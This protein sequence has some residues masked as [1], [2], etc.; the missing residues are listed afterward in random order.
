MDRNLFYSLPEHLKQFKF[1]TKIDKNDNKFTRA[2]Y[3]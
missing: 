2:Q 3:T 1:C